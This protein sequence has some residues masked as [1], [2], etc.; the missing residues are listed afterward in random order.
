MESS[1]DTRELPSFLQHEQTLKQE[2]QPDSRTRLKEALVPPE[3]I[4]DKMKTRVEEGT[5]VAREKTSDR[6]EQE[7]LERASKIFLW[8]L[9]INDT[10]QLLPEGLVFDFRSIDKTALS[11]YWTDPYRLIC[12]DAKLMRQQ[13]YKKLLR[14]FQRE[15]VLTD[16]EE[17]QRQYRTENRE[18]IADAIESLIRQ[19][20]LTDFLDSFAINSED[21]T[22]ERPLNALEE[23][24]ARAQRD[25]KFKNTWGALPREDI[26]RPDL[27]QRYR[28]EVEGPI[29]ATTIQ[30]R[31]EAG[32]RKHDIPR[33]RYQEYIKREF[34]GSWDY[35]RLEHG[36]EYKNRVSVTDG[37]FVYTPAHNP[38]IDPNP[39]KKPISLKDSWWRF[40]TNELWHP[41]DIYWQQAYFPTAAFNH[42]GPKLYDHTDKRDYQTIIDEEIKQVTNNLTREIIDN[43]LTLEHPGCYRAEKLAWLNQTLGPV[44]EGRGY[45]DEW[46][47]ITEE[48]LTREKDL[49]DKPLKETYR[50]ENNNIASVRSA[51]SIE[52]DRNTHIAHV[53]FSQPEIFSNTQQRLMHT[54]EFDPAIPAVVSMSSV[55]AR[56]RFTDQK[57]ANSQLDPFIYGMKLVARRGNFYDFQLD[58]EHEL[59]KRVED[60]LSTETRAELAQGYIAIGMYPLAQEIITADDLT[61]SGFIDLARQYCI[62]WLPT[63]G[64]PE[65]KFLFNNLQTLADNGLIDEQG[66]LR[67]QC[68]VFQQFLNDALQKIYPDAIIENIGGPSFKFQEVINALGHGQVR[69]V[70]PEKNLD[71]IFDIEPSQIEGDY[72]A[73]KAPAA[74]PQLELDELI[75]LLAALKGPDQPP[76]LDPQIKIQAT[77]IEK[78]VH[79]DNAINVF[80]RDLSTYLDLRNNIHDFEKWKAE[81]TKKLGPAFR[82][83]AQHWEKFAHIRVFNL[84]RHYQI[85]EGL[86]TNID[87]QEILRIKKIL[88][89]YTEKPKH[90]QKMIQT[91]QVP[92]YDPIFLQNMHRVVDT[93]LAEEAK[94]DVNDEETRQVA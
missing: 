59:Y 74:R 58:S 88:N 68:T 62:W 85:Q 20:Q 33:T 3:S 89:N 14:T 82:K 24:K 1:V 64:T 23:S 77:K 22:A 26:T 11:P 34:F 47:G 31:K 2:V 43:G 37:E 35:Y 50:R 55:D 6:K 12:F 46:R 67:G 52:K 54:K 42:I 40:V 76:S 65:T 93:L 7:M 25:E 38:D 32:R 69:V 5:Q 70:N 71:N 15:G 61:T 51:E 75:R 44:K 90:F 78:K 13:T 21:E 27:Q 19:S 8:E 9:G 49:S 79:A 73:Q 4:A 72:W 92:A 10:G 57:V 86:D 91:G 39:Q 17:L 66:N 41:K 48:E 80:A 94:K 53:V 30:R 28:N 84:L 18:E 81:A 16:V 60:P 29:M 63:K 45:I 36:D 83:G 56:L 87:P